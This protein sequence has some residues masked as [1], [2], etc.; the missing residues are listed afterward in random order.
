MLS[1]V[2]MLDVAVCAG[3]ER[4]KVAEGPLVTRWAKDVSPDNALPEYPRP[5]MVRKDWLNLN[6]LW[7]L[8]VT[9]KDAAKPASFTEWILVPFPIESALSGVM[10]RVDE[11][12]RIW[13]RRTFEL[14]GAWNG[15][16][17]LLHF[18]AVDWESVVYV[19]GK[20]QGDHRGGYDAF[21][22]DITDSLK[23]SGPQEVIVSVWDPT[24]TA[25]QPRGKQV[26]N[27]G[28]IFYTPTT[29]IWQTVWLEPVP[30]NKY[31]IEGLKLTP[32]VDN[33]R[34]VVEL[35]PKY[36]SKSNAVEVAVFDGGKEV[37][38]GSGLAKTEVEI[39]NPKLWSPESPFLYDLR[40]TLRSSNK[41][42]NKPGKV[43]DEVKSYFGMRKIEIGKDKEGI[44]RI[45][46]N[47]KFLF[48]IG[49]LDQ[50]FWPDGLYT[51]PT[52]EALR[53]DVEITRKLGFNMARKHVKIE[54]ARWYYWCDKL[55]LLVWQDMAAGDNNSEAEKKQF[56]KELQNLIEGFYNHPSIVMWVIFN[57]GWGQHD[58][59]RLAAWV[60]QLDPSR[61]VNNASGWTDR[62][63][64][65]VFDMHSYPGPGS[66]Q[67]EEARAAVL[68][69]FGGLGLKIPGH[70]W[71][72]ETW[73]YQ[74][75]ADREALTGRY[76]QLLQGVAQLSVTPGL[77]AAVYTQT[78]DIETECNGLL[79]YDREVVKVDIDRAALAN[80]GY[81]PPTFAAEADI[82][83]DQTTV[84]LA[85]LQE[86][87]SIYYTLDGSEPTGKSSLYTTGIILKETAVVKARSYW[88]DG[89]K[90]AVA[91][92]TFT[93]VQP[94]K[95]V[96][97]AQTTDGLR[98][99]YYEFM[100]RW[101]KLG[102]F[103]N[104][105]PIAFGI[106]NKFDLSPSRRDRDYALKFTG[107]LE[108][109]QAGVYVFSINSDDGT[110]LYIGDEVIVDNDGVHGMK[111]EEGL[112]ALEA[113]RHP[114]KVL[115]FQGMGGKGLEVFYSGPG[116]KKRQ[117]PAEV[118][119]HATPP[120]KPN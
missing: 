120:D 20:E 4:W 113:G 24:N 13:Y 22:Y 63:V 52:D 33:S 61:L 85:Q 26:K 99:N 118:L 94:R 83:I 50:G 42:N 25:G 11:S 57:E 103:S 5:Q 59:E 27:P 87:A 84:E 28:G 117:I 1:I 58:T 31:R 64:G 43:I 69:E 98:Y 30:K 90:S 111:E 56:E 21:N 55:G 62:G 17:I 66:P 109:A 53:Y 60:K 8:A 93:K 9:E 44:T 77:S 106:C 79:T 97:V 115:F 23:A 81:V 105:K 80:Q 70:V 35:D 112:V 95:P 100:D 14:P 51:A 110:R 76:E 38:S 86:T 107:Y 72:D 88:P 102:D 34:L 2:L 74:N 73:G 71:Q 54:P 36:L 65:D 75:M 91:V 104:L 32:D 46:L 48:Q 49:P 68:G 39:P 7:E 37:A 6:G 12:N 16:R 47:G 114:I 116:V 18:G 96:E 89:R 108:I 45:L 67:P 82:F 101:E 10:K 78:S 41:S 19:N 40:I 92:H 15:K 3:A 29:G 119:S